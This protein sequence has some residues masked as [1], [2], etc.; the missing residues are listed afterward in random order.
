MFPATRALD[1]YPGI[2]LSLVLMYPDST[3]AVLFIAL[4]EKQT[5]NKGDTQSGIYRGI[6]SPKHD[7]GVGRAK[8]LGTV[9]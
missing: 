1:V 7:K 5:M 9:V 8:H 3:P 6:D 4:L 2:M